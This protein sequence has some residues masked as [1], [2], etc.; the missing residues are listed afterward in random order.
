MPDAI[1]EPLLVCACAP[2]TSC[3]SVAPAASYS[4]KTAEKEL[5]SLHSAWMLVPSLPVAIASYQTRYDV[6]PPLLT[7]LIRSVNPASNEPVFIVNT[8]F[9]CPLMSIPSKLPA[10][11]A[12]TVKSALK[13][14]DDSTPPTAWTKSPK[15]TASHK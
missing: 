11:G 2:L 12:V 14:K 8:P 10:V 5:K 7:T 13:S 15:A 4:T 9:V 6:L 3:E 1:V